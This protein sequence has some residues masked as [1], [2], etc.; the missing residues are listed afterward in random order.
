MLNGNPSS[1]TCYLFSLVGQEKLGA[2]GF[3]NKQTGPIV[4]QKNY[5]GI[6]LMAKMDV[7]DFYSGMGFC[8]EGNI[9]MYKYMYCLILG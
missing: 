6:M 7:M 2:S 9:P 3:Q 4:F 1:K 8:L 5:L